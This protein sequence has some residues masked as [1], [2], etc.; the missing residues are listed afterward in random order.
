MKK[1][2]FLSFCENINKSFIV[3]IGILSE[4][5]T[6]VQL[7]LSDSNKVILVINLIL[8]VAIVVCYSIVEKRAKLSLGLVLLAQDGHIHTTRMLILKDNIQKI[9]ET[10][11]MYKQNDFFAD[12]VNFS[13]YIRNKINYVSDLVYQHRFTLNPIKKGEKIFTPWFFG[14]EE[15]TPIECSYRTDGKEWNNLIPSTVVPESLD[16]AAN[17]GIY[18]TAIPLGYM[19]KKDKKDI[20]FKYERAKAF[21]WDRPEIFVIWPKCYANKMDK[22]NFSIVFDEKVERVVSIV[23]YVCHGKKPTKRTKAILKYSYIDGETRY[24]QNNLAIDPENVYVIYITEP[25]KK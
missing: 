9:K 12:N 2:R 14:E 17:E 16:Y 21:R 10:E 3:I 24:T 20:E 25:K 1:A 22:A 5:I 18:T 8:F 11:S 6:I 4:A 13:F 15:A 7:F 19:N 23:E